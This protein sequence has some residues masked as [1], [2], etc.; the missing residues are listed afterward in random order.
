MNILCEAAKVYRQFK[1]ISEKQDAY[2]LN[3]GRYCAD[4]SKIVTTFTTS[5][6][7]DRDVVTI[8]EDGSVFVERIQYYPEYWFADTHD[9]FNDTSFKEQENNLQDWKLTYNSANRSVDRKTDYHFGSDVNNV[10]YIECFKTVEYCLKQYPFIWKC[11]YVDFRWVVNVNIKYCKYA[12]KYHADYNIL[13][14]ES[15]N[16]F[17]SFTDYEL[18]LRAFYTNIPTHLMNNQTIAPM[19]DI[20]Y[21][22]NI[23]RKKKIQVLV[24]DLIN[25]KHIYIDWL[26]GRY[27]LF[28]KITELF[29]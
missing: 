19:F 13:N 15:L 5:E 14:K 25:N 20:Y 23:A 4:L 10:S 29:K 26:H 17:D 3:I 8:Y 12:P 2:G 16:H 6:Y 9:L 11:D 18:W 24:I 7:G 22:S 1:K 28:K 27:G 21:P